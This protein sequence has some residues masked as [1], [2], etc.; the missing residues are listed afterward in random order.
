MNGLWSSLA[1]LEARR[2][3]ILSLHPCKLTEFNT[4]G[5]DRCMLTSKDYLSQKHRDLQAMAGM[6]EG[7]GYDLGDRK[8]T[9]NLVSNKVVFEMSRY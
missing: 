7:Q 6:E 4:V 3:G 8:S 2:C 1:V 5:T 9:K